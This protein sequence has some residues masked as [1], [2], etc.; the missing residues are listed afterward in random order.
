M[1]DHDHPAASLEVIGNGSEA[2]RGIEI[3]DHPEVE[4][5]ARDLGAEPLAS[6]KEPQVL[7]GG[8][9][10]YQLAFEPPAL[11]IKRDRES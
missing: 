10:A 5:A 6:R 3:E 11:Q 7:R 8:V 2:V 1:I 4:R 9:V